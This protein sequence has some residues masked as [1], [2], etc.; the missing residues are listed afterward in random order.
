MNPVVAW[1]V[2]LRG[3]YNDTT[4]FA[5]AVATDAEGNVI[6]GGCLYNRVTAEDFTVIK[7]DGKTGEELWRVE[8]N[9]TANGRDQVN[10]LAVD[11][12]GDVIAAGWL[13]N[14]NTSFD[15]A[16]VKLDGKTGAEL[17]RVEIN[18]TANRED[19]A[20]A[21]AVDSDGHVVAVGEIRNII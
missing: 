7:L 6:A 3:T 14:R 2:T 1:Q 4:N 12:R 21:V 13:L 20:T 17:W 15:F 5:N 19:E 9:G 10:A 11:A 16:V 18:G 8:I